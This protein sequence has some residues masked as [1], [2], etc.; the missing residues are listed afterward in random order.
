MTDDKDRLALFDIFNKS[1]LIKSYKDM[2]GRI[3]T[4]EQIAE[5]V[6]WLK[7]FD[8]DDLWGSFQKNIKKMSKQSEALF[9]D[10]YHSVFGS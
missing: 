6:K 2:M 7:I 10:F 9:M 8:F 5:G 4:K 3:A 1:D